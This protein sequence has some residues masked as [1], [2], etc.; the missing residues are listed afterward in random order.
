MNSTLIG[1]W[2]LVKSNY[3]TVVETQVITNYL[4]HPFI[5]KN[6]MPACY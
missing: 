5:R 1:I 3:S 2:G 4:D 6:H